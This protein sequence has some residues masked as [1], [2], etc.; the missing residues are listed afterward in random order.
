MRLIRSPKL[1]P[2]PQ[3]PA[4]G[5]PLHPQPRHDAEPSRSKRARHNQDTNP[6]DELEQVVRARDDSEAESLGD[7][8]L[9]GAAGTEVG[10]DDVGVE[11]GELAEEVYCQTGGDDVGVLPLLERCRG[12]RVRGKDPVGDVEHGEPVVRQVPQDVGGGHGGGGEAVE[13]DG[14]E[15]ALDEVQDDEGEGDGLHG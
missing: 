6:R 11:V 8:A 1:L 10:E 5:P 4:H 13:E 7:S 2:V 14:F 9:G 3:L 15:L 12:N